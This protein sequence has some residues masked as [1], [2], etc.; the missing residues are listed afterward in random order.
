MTWVSEPAE[1]NDVGLGFKVPEG[2]MAEAD[3]DGPGLLGKRI[4]LAF[5]VEGSTEMFAGVVEQFSWCHSLPGETELLAC[6]RMHFTDGSRS[7]HSL[8]DQEWRHAPHW[9]KPD[10]VHSVNFLPPTPK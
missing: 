1:E 6:H 2:T 4:E 9:T 7:W 3:G 8:D 5:D 10:D